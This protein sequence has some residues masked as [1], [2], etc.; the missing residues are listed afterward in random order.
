VSIPAHTEWRWNFSW[1]AT[2][3]DGLAQALSPL[4]VEFLIGGEKVGEDAFRMYNHAEGSWQC[5]TWAMLMAGWQAGDTTDLEIHYTLKEPV[6]DGKTA[7]PAG[8]YR[9][10]IHL[11]VV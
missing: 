6:N 2:T 7:Y 4:E 5:R 8:E 1:C 9:Q 10:I 11:S 3:E